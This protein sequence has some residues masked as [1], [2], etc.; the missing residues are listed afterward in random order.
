VL[1]AQQPELKT[2]TTR[3]AGERVDSQEQL[4]RHTK[5]KKSIAASLLVFSMIAHAE[6]W[7]HFIDN[8]DGGLYADKDS[9]N[10]QGDIG[11]VVIRIGSSG[12]S[13]I[14]SFDCNRAVMLAREKEYPV[15][16]NDP[17]KKAF[18]IA[19]KKRWEVWK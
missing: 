1:A 8:P 17:G 5:M 13:G 14:W 3:N 7:V 6:N 11:S 2:G 16:D 9:G 19:C 12:R 18:E 15:G 4:T 10:R